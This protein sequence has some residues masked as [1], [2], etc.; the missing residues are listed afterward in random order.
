MLNK[1]SLKQLNIQI[2]HNMQISVIL[3]TYN[4][5]NHLDLVLTGYRVQTDQNFEIIIADDGSKS[6]T[7]EVVKKHQKLAHLVIHHLWQ[8]DNGFRKT[9]ILNKAIKLST[10]DYLIFSDG[11]CVPRCDFVEMH[12]KFAETEHYVTGAYNRLS[13]ETTERVTT[14]L[15]E[16]KRLFSPFW[17]ASNGYI[18]KKGFLRIIL[19]NILGQLLDNFGKVDFGRFTGGNASCFRSDAMAIDGFNEDMTYGRE[20][21]EFGT[22]LCN[23]GLTS[24]R[25]KHSTYVLHLEHERPYANEDVNSKNLK[26]LTETIQTGRSKSASG[27]N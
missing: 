10:S 25:L 20:D 27:I 15:I 5:P 22:R 17:L 16:S 9:T 2:R 18:P 12:R 23:F 14:H 26:I 8:E 19:P 21:R 24:K 13:L 7:A 1:T 6:E 4:Q 11:D 3:S